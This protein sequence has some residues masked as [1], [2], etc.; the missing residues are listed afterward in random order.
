[1]N[2]R[3][4]IKVKIRTLHDYI[5]REYLG[6]TENLKGRIFLLTFWEK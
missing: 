6:E 3:S 5:W 2:K 4:R 1:M